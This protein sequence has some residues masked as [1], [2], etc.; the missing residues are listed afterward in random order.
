MTECSKAFFLQ[1]QE[2]KYIVQHSDG[3]EE[4]AKGTD[5]LSFPQQVHGL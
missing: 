5:D 4:K 2:G 1:F 3:K